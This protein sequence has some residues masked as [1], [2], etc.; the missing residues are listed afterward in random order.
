MYIGL[1][2]K[3]PLFVS[4][5]N[6]TCIFSTDFRI[7]LKFNENLSSERRVVPCGRAGGQTSKLVVAFRNFANAPINEVYL[8]Q[9]ETVIPL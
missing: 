1:H 9:P 3:N 8:S 6:Q 7:T 5:F 2:A 4:D